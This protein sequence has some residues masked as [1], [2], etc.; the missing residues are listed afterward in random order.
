LSDAVMAIKNQAD[1]QTATQIRDFDVR[2]VIDN[3]I[4]DK[5]VKEGFF[6]KLF[7][8]GIRAE[9]ERKSKMAVR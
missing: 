8:P 7:G 4:I 9:I 5:L 2:T 1:S 6:E 3:S